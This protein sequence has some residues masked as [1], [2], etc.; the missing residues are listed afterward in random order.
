[1]PAVTASTAELPDWLKDAEGALEASLQSDE[2][3]QPVGQGARTAHLIEQVG[4]K[5]RLV[6]EG[7]A[8]LRTV[9]P[10]LCVIACAGMY[11]T[12]KSYFLNSLSG[13][14][15]N[16]TSSAGS[17]AVGSTSESCTRGID[18][19]IPDPAVAGVP[20]SGG[21]LVLLDTEGL[22]ALDQDETYDAQIFSLA[23][24]LS[25]YFVLNSVG[26][27]DEAAVDRLFLVV[28]LSKHICVQANGAAGAAAAARDA[29]LSQFFPP[30]LWLL[31]DFV[32][33]LEADG[34]PIDEAEYMERALTGRAA[35]GRRASE[36]NARRAAERNEV[37]NAIR[38]LFPRRTCRTM[39]RPVVSEEDLKH[40]MT[41]S[42]SQL[43]PE[44]VTKLAQLK[45]EVLRAAPPKALFGA[46]LDGSALV[47]LASQYLDAM[48]EPDAIPTIRTPHSNRPCPTRTVPHSDPAHYD[49]V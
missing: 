19:C 46:H 33:D 17:F 5:W 48:N 24:L 18:V 2:E 12:G 8:L 40:A 21:T 29:E 38:S 45:G 10:P 3:T 37:R 49:L 7:V 23:L 39:V 25:S 20:A 43:R 22:A 26:V 35:G 36:S 15:G 14:A 28:E 9:P 31:R 34:V 47:A 44:F 13:V 30:L 16:A 42:H 41:L 27:I 32:V 1:M 11:R 4:G 6:D